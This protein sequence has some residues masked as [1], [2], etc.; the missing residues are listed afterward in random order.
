MIVAIRITTASPHSASTHRF[1]YQGE[2]PSAA[3]KRSVSGLL[4]SRSE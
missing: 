2:V 4:T 3:R 1:R